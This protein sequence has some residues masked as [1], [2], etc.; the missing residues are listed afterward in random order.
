MKRT[1]ISTAFLLMAAISFCQQTTTLTSQDYLTKS[2]KQKGAA[3]GLLAGGTAL[4]GVGLLIGNGK[5]SSFD[6][7]STGGIIAIVGGVAILSS[8]PLF[9]ASTRNKK[10]GMGTSL[11]FQIEKTPALQLARLSCRSYY[12]A[13][14]FK[15]SL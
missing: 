9:L 5:E 1:I 10:K 4:I 7:A 12:P 13:L 8:I 6:D 3:W 11:N 15:L 2:K 14:S